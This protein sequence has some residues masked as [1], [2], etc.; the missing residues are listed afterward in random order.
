MTIDEISGLDEL[1]NEQEKLAD[2]NIRTEATLGDD[3][4]DL[5]AVY[6]GLSLAAFLLGLGVLVGLCVCKRGSSRT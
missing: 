2:V 5:T 4:P 3:G 1:V 6:V